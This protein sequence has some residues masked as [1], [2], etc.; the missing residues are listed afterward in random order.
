M[1]FG[2]GD[3]G[4]SRED[5][6][7]ISIKSNFHLNFQPSLPLKAHGKSAKFTKPK[8][9]HIAALVVDLQQPVAMRRLTPCVHRHKRPFVEA[10][11]R[12]VMDPAGEH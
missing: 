9:T 2:G 4:G 3:D 10:G 7:K 8:L 12:H 5:S 6:L 11:T 1:W